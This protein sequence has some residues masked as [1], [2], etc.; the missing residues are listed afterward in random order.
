MH[1]IC[2]YP[3]ISTWF[4]AIEA[5]IFVGWPLLTA[6]NVK[7]YY[8][9]TTETPKGH[10]NQTRTNMRTTKAP[11]QLFEL[12]DT[13]KIK[14]KKERAIFTKVYDVRK[15]ICPNPT[16]QFPARSMSGNKYVMVM[17]E[18]DSSG[19]LVKPMKNCIDNEMIRAYQTLVQWLQQANI[20]SRKHVLDNELSE[21]MKELMRSKYNMQLELVP[22]GCHRRNAAEV[23]IC[24]FK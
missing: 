4:V 15:T 7:K 3:V 1:A 17:V 13:S 21:S 6:R 14:G 20:T 16:G 5:G 12:C 23:A 22:P 11:P 9:E 8:T 10:M 19:I 2:G 24:N 18:I